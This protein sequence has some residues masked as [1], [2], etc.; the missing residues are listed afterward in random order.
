MA[1]RIT[2]N[3]TADGR[4]LMREIEKLVSKEV[5]VGFKAGENSDDNGVDICNIAIWN[6]LGTTRSPARPFMRKSVDE[7]I[8]KINN[9]L[10]RT[11][12]DILSGKS[13]EEVLKMI[14]IF[15]KDLIQEKI[16]NGSFVPNTPYTIRKKGSDKPLIDTGRMRQSV[17]YVIKEKGSD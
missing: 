10:K 15:Q 2:D 3:I 13:A 1:V 7:N 6:E 17:N 11:K 8:D 4:K 16:T 9:F 5:C 14:G 12:R